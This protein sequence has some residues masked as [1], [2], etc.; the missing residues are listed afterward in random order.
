MSAPGNKR[1]SKGPRDEWGTP[2]ELFELL[3]REFRF[4]LEVC[5]SEE[6]HKMGRY[7]SGPCL[8]E[9]VQLD[10]TVCGC[11]LCTSWAGERCF[12]NPPYSCVE[13]WMEKA[14]AEVSAPGRQ[15]LVVAL[16]PN[17][18]E[19][20]WFRTAWGASAYV[21]LLHGRVPFVEPEAVR[22]ERLSK[23]GEEGGNTGGS[24]V[25]VMRRKAL[26]LPPLVSIWDWEREVAEMRLERFAGAAG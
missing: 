17:A 10:G 19:V 13:A 8:G 4:T 21:R 15:T 11:G 22:S 23:G 1:R 16:V 14:E 5:A 18:T 9:G 7:L 20:D 24:A 25:F 2:V 3:D 6:N 26:R 12:M